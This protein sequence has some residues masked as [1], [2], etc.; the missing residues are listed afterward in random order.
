[1][2]GEC[3][4][5]SQTEVRKKT[6]EGRFKPTRSRPQQFLAG[7]IPVRECI[8]P[9]SVKLV[10]CAQMLVEADEGLVRLGGLDLRCVREAV[11]GVYTLEAGGSRKILVEHRRHAAGATRNHR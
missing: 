3:V 11:V 8:H 2:G 10:V 5:F 1:M 4:A 7:H 9:T 6:V